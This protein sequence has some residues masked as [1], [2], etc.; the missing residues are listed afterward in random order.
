M[1]DFVGLRASRRTSSLDG[2]CGSLSSLTSWVGSV[3]LTRMIPWRRSIRSAVY[4]ITAA[5]VTAFVAWGT[6]RTSQS[7]QSASM[8]E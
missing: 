4:L 1:M 7:W 8:S 2:I 5:A 6:L 3:S